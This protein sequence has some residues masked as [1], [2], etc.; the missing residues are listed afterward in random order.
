MPYR[1]VR[2]TP[3][4]RNFPGD[5]DTL[6]TITLRPGL[7]VGRRALLGLTLGL[8]TATYGPPARA[9]MPRRGGKM[10]FGRYQDATYLDP[11]M[12]QANADIW[13]LSNL[14]DNLVELGSDAKVVLPGLATKWEI[15]PDARTVTFVLREGV[16]FADGSLL[17]AEDIKFSLQ[18]AG[19]PT[20]GFWASMLAAVKSI[21]IPDPGLLVLNLNNPAPALLPILSMYSF[22]VLPKNLIVAQPGNTV[23]DKMKHFMDH[24]IGSGPFVLG[25]WQRNQVMRLKRNPYYWK[26]AADGKQLPYLDEVEFQ[27]IPDDSTRILKLLAGEI[28]GAELIPYARIK[29]LQ[30]NPQLRV[31]LWPSTKRVFFVMNVRPTLKNGTANPLSD[32]RVRRALNYAV[33]KEAV[34]QVATAGIGTPMR[35]FLSA[36]V[37][38]FYGPPQLYPYDPAKAK[39][40]LKEAGV[41]EGLQLSVLTLAGSLDEANAAVAVQQMW[42]QVGVELKIEQVE[43]ATRNAR[44][45]VGDFQMRYFGGTDDVGD[46]TEAGASAAYYPHNES[47]HSGWQ[48][49]RSDELYVASEQEPDPQK[50]AAQ[51]KEMQ[52]IFNAAAPMLFLY[53]APYPTAFRKNAKG[54]VQ[55]PLGTNLFEVAYLET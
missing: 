23:E 26:T 7:P 29:E 14:F 19:D 16:K 3:A 34:I 35:S 13:L 17:T 8:A 49:K 40:L 12:A 50:R 51:Y 43:G 25:E 31:D 4:M 47:R 21:E 18:R 10:I 39:A 55:N 30:D 2:T 48:D 20:I 9:D 36:S 52:E 38:L 37:P 44:W 45:R 22:C 11:I 1:Y 33:S 28:H 53:E 6:E 41:A 5:A 27:L 32:V 46:P 15:S 42:V 54:F 24:P